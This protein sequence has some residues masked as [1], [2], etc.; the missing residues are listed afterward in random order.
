[1]YLCHIL[2]S[3]KKHVCST[4]I[5]P[6]QHKAKHRNVKSYFQR[7]IFQYYICYTITGEHLSYWQDSS[8]A[9]VLY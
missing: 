7:K 4:Q 3:N 5:T 2:K 6:T 1:M 8:L 9:E